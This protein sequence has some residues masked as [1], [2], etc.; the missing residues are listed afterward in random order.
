GQCAIEQTKLIAVPRGEAAHADD[1]QMIDAIDPHL[2][3][4]REPVHE[5]MER[6]VRLLA[7]ADPRADEREPGEGHLA[8]LLDPGERDR[9]EIKVVGNGGDEVPKHDPDKQVNDREH[10]QRG[11]GDFRKN[12]E[13]PHHAL[14]SRE[15]WPGQSGS[16]TREDF[17]AD[18]GF[19][20]AQSGLQRYA[21]KAATSSQSAPY[22]LL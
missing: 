21:L 8:N 17:S 2:R 13:K 16:K 11:R 14:T 18:S 12:R 20:V 9:I 10:D 7:H 1:Q 5:N 15:Q 22:W 3:A 4:P 6:K 19:R